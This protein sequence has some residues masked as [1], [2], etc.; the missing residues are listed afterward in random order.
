MPKFTGTLKTEWMPSGKHWRVTEAF[1][2]HSGQFNSGLFVSVPEGFVTD[3]A[4]IPIGV[5][6]LIPKAGKNA[7][8][9]VVH[10][11]IYRHGT[12]SIRVRNN[13]Q[14]VPVSRGMA[15][16]IMYQA[17][18]ALNVAAWRRELIFR[19]LQVGG[20]V[21]WNRLRRKNIGLATATTR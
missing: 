4:S 14:Q 8:A 2:F 6:W 7:Q 18:K 9:A 21:A 20:W 3:L 17:M 5:R 11:H 19:G 12:M 16:A 10:D 15:D 13:T 1:E